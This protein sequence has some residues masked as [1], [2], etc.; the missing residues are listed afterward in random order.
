LAG[1]DSVTDTRVLGEDG[2][3]IPNWTD[4]LPPIKREAKDDFVDF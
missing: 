4:K 1:R 3:W 2:W